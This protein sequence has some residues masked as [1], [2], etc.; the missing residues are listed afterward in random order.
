MARLDLPAPAILALTRKGADLAREL[1]GFLGADL[2]LTARA[3]GSDSPDASLVENVP[4]TL[5]SLFLAGQ[6]IVALAASGIVIR[7]LAPV[8]LSKTEEPPVLALAEDRSVVVP[9]LGGHQGANALARRIAEAIGA[10]PALST[11]GERRLGIA[12]DE[13][14]RGWVLENPQDAKAAMAALLDGARVRV[15]GEREGL[16]EWLAP[17]QESITGSDG[18][19]EDVTL[20]FSPEAGAE[21]VDDADGKEGNGRHVLRYRPKRFVLGA[22]CARNCP[23]NEVRQ[24]AETVLSE[25][26]IAP[27]ALHSIATIDLKADEAALNALAELWSVPVQLF[28]SEALERETPR[29]FSPSPVVKAEVGT[30]GVA[31]N[32]ALAAAGPMSELRIAK[33]K[34]AMATA[35]LAEAPKPIDELRGRR[36]GRLAVVGIGPGCAPWRTPEASRLIAEAEELVGYGLYL[37]L[38]G[39]SAHGKK[40]SEFPLGGEEARCRYAL[41]AAGE[42]RNVALISSGDAGIYAMGA[43]VCELLDRGE[44]AGISDAARRAELVFAPG[45]TAMQAAAARVGAPLG[46]DFCAISLS[47]LLTPRETILAR[48]EA[49][50]RGDFVTA[51]YNP[52]SRRRRELLGK[53]RDILLEHRPR[54][55]PVILARNLGREDEA[56]EVIELGALTADKVDMLT[57][58][59]VGSSTSRVLFRKGRPMVYTPRGYAQK[60]GG[61]MPE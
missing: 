9:L 31:E 6:P 28:D 23:P 39:P 18:S 59:L 2:F 22:G 55:T 54:S 43:L 12:L 20:V 3:G 45:I 33:H 38:L 16:E 60:A 7:A 49:A 17:L 14:P 5:R 4:E 26:G 32:A 36:R 46:H 10:F 48:L 27:S 37:D 13:P 44:E 50:A 51:F 15:V 21:N 41:K 29:T 24:V 11:A 52:V 57:L 8:L 56:I 53:A 58:V 42:G 40:R 35:A 61:G 34:S 1:A 19:G 30:H 25:A 47:D